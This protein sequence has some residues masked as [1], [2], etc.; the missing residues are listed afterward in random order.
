V[1]VT[2]DRKDRDTF[3][4][5]FKMA[6]DIVLAEPECAYLFVGETVQ[7]PGVFHWTAGW[8]K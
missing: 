4:K 1:R 7:E 2:V 8:T 6:Y 3:V 5:H